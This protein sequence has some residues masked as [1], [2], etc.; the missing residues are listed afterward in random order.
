VHTL[1]LNDLRISQLENE[2]LVVK[3]DFIWSQMPRIYTTLDYLLSEEGRAREKAWKPL[4]VTNKVVSKFY[5]IPG[6]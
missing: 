3:D 5:D 1:V 4:Q 6:G 2:V